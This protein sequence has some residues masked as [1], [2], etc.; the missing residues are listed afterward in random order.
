MKA[1]KHGVR[2]VVLLA[3][4]AL[5]VACPEPASDLG[6]MQDEFEVVL[7]LPR[8]NTSTDRSTI[9]DDTAVAKVYAKVFNSS[10][11]HLPSTDLSGVTELKWDD[12]NT[13]WSATVRL[14]SAAS[15]EI[16]FF[17]WAENT[18]GQHL[19]SGD[20]NLTVGTN[21]NTIAVTTGEGYSLR[22]MGPGGGYIFYDKGSYS[23]GWR[24][25]EAARAGWSGSAYDPSYIYG[26]YMPDGST[27]TTMGT[28]TGVGTGEANTLALVSSM[29]NTAYN[30]TYGGGTTANYAAKMCA[31]HTGGGCEDWFLPSKD[32]LNLMYQNLKLSSV[33]VFLDLYYWS[34]SENF[35]FADYGDKIDY[36]YAWA[37]GFEYG[38]QPDTTYRQNSHRVRPVRAF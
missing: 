35:K 9:N 15:G 23:N 29:Q 32:E 2:L 19:Y 8:D 24:Y 5:M 30:Y 4:C 12:S 11:V 22:D 31:D 13:K 38:N 14:A 34:S 10:R 16:T 26:H 37:Q 27:N 3:V 25:L 17:V 7:D 20:G 21:N 33:G 36:I 28:T 6:G 1:L 18:T